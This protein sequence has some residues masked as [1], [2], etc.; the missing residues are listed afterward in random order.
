[1]SN[2]VSHIR[3]FVADRDVLNLVALKLSA[4]IERKV[5]TGEVLNGV[6]QLLEPE[7]KKQADVISKKLASVLG[8]ID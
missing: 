5:S 6:L 4:T 7:R 2:D 1:M 8:A 3:V